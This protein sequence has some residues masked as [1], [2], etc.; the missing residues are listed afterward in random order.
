MRLTSIGVVVTTYGPTPFLRQALCSLQH[1]TYRD[2]RC[3]VVDDGGARTAV[4]AV[5]PFL[6]DT[7]FEFVQRP[8]GGVCRARNTGAE[9]LSTEA[10][11]LLFLD[12]D[13]VLLPTALETLWGRLERSPHL[14]GAHAL[15]RLVDADGRPLEGIPFTEQQRARLTLRG[16]KLVPVDRDRT[17]FEDLVTYSRLQPPSLALVRRHA[18]EQ[19]GGWD[20]RFA[21]VEDWEFFLRLLRIGDMGF[22]DDVVVDYRRHGAN[23]S[24]DLAAMHAAVRRL[25]AAVFFTPEENPHRWQSQRM[26]WRLHQRRRAAERFTQAAAALGKHDW[27]ESAWSVARGV[28]HVALLPRPPR[29]WLPMGE[30]APRDAYPGPGH[31]R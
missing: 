7:R 12:E 26:A 19:V 23:A 11:N 22:V 15:A 24:D 1:Q 5:R 18:F 17:V 3:V 28:G 31:K 6:D 9:L 27:W 2:F 30:G 14:V 8:H 25:R 20:Q 10:E 13:D 29:R 4:S 21:L 16:R